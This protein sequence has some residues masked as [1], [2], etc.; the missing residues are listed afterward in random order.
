MHFTAP[1]IGCFWLVFTAYWLISSV[2]VKKNATGGRWRRAMGIRFV[3]ILVF[4]LFWRTA[5]LRAF[6]SRFGALSA[7]SSNPVIAGLGVLLC[8]VGIGFA[9]WARRHIGRNWGMPMSLKE[10]PELVTTGPY[11]MVRHP[12]YSGMILAMAGSILGMGVVWVMPFI[13]SCGY[14]VYSARTEEGLMLERFPATYPAYMARTKM[15][16]PFIL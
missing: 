10:D 5:A 4:S 12:I 15:L 7:P 1:L 16:I 14:F 13:L 8:A 11:T 6:A 3:I 9:I 2:G